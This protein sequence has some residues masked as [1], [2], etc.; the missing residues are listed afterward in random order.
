VLAATGHRESDR[1]TTDAIAHIAAAAILACTCAAGATAW[2]AGFSSKRLAVV[3]PAYGVLLAAGSYWSIHLALFFVGMLAPLLSHNIATA[4]GARV[5]GEDLLKKQVA[6][7]LLK[8][9]RAQYAAVSLT[10]AILRATPGLLLVLAAP[11]GHPIAAL[12]WGQMVSVVGA[13]AS[14]MRITVWPPHALRAEMERQEGQR[15]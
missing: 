12:G 5:T 2:W 1:V 4:W 14:V 9:G 6:A 13:V 8:G 11:S 3:W 10:A 7:L 15:A